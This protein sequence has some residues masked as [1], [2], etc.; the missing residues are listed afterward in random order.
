M[1]D[2]W[3]VKEQG[4]WRYLK[5]ELY[6]RLLDRRVLHSAKGIFFTTL[7]RTWSDRLRPLRVPGHDGDYRAVRR[8]S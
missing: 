7:R 4:I 6:L 1:L 8:R 5:K 3:A 2:R